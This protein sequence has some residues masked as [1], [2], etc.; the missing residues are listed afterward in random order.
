MYSLMTDA[1]SWKTARE[2]KNLT[3]TLENSSQHEK[4]Y[5]EQEQKGIKLMYFFCV[6]VEMNNFIT[7]PRKHGG[8]TTNY[9][10]L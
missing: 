2:T 4:L 3:S 8:G 10:A 1:M 5:A 6:Y 7:T 9:E